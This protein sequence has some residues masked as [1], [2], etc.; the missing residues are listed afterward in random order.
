[1][2]LVPEPRIKVAALWIN[3]L[4]LE[5]IAAEVD[6]INFAPRVTIPVLQLNGRYD[7]NFPEESSSLPFFNTLGMPADKRRRVVYDTGHDL[8]F[9][10][11]FRETIDW[12][13]RHLGPPR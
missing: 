11:A 13:D 4:Y 5:T 9:N 1:M 8:P 2:M 3:G 6:A 12:F 7:Y 10:E